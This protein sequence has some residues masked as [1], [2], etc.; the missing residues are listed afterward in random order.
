MHASSLKP[1]GHPS[2]HKSLAAKTS[3][4]TKIISGTSRLCLSSLMKGLAHD[5]NVPACSVLNS[6]KSS[7]TEIIGIESHVSAWPTRILYLLCI[8]NFCVQ[9]NGTFLIANS[10]LS[11][12]L[13]LCSSDIDWTVRPN[14]YHLERH[15]E[16]DVS[17]LAASPQYLITCGNTSSHVWK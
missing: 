16:L 1:E 12:E 9:N 14:P 11:E 15:R 10:G 8:S 4:G 7:Q 17:V 2:E 3:F 13:W 5:P 6:E